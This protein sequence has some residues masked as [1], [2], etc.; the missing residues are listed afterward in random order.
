MRGTQDIGLVLARHRPVCTS[1][2]VEAKPSLRDGEYFVYCLSVGRAFAP[3][4]LAGEPAAS[5]F[6]APTFRD[7]GARIARTRAAS[8]RRPSP[9]LVQVVVDQQADLPTSP[10]RQAHCDALA[11][12]R[13]AVVVTGQQVGLFLGPLY[14]FYKAASA[15]AVARAL[16]AESGVPC[17]PVFWLQTEDHDFAEIRTAI[18][19]DPNGEPVRLDLP[20]DPSQ[21]A[22]TSVAYR[23]LPAQ[24]REL[25]STLGVA[26]DGG[27]GAD[28]VL[29]LLQDS[30]LPGAGLHR[31]FASLLATVFADEGLLVFNPRDAR[32]AAL[33]APFY[34]RCIE[35]TAPIETA[36]RER[37]VA[38]HTAGFDV[39]VPIRDHGAL[40]F[41]HR[42]TA[43]G[44]R[45]RLQQ[46]GENW[47]LAGAAERFSPEALRGLL[48]RDPLRFST[49]ALLR[50][51]VQDLLFPTAAYV[52]GPGEINYYAQMGPLYAFAGLT[53]PLLVPRG[54][55]VVVDART[56]RRLGQLGLSV[57]DV[58]VPGHA[59][60]AR[61]QDL[62]DGAVSVDDLRRRIATQVT[63]A[64][65]DLA[66]AARL[67][68]IGLERPA[69]RTLNSVAHALNRLLDRYAH[70]LLERDTIARR[71]LR[72]VE[73]ALFPNGTPQER[74]Y[75]WPHLAARLGPRTLKDLVMQ[76]LA[77]AGPF[78]SKVH[79]LSP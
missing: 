44:P 4:Y 34:R 39:Q 77:S 28:E 7:A 48:D 53:P 79:E 52:A 75:A 56:R 76:R 78:G 62:P 47:Q 30:Y 65:E 68:G 35:E 71:R 64:V 60:R 22:R 54:R 11:S 31:A 16:Q 24:V 43:S 46:K 32:I 42:E 33:A 23:T 57:R 61:V 50:P 15:I 63:P 74:F 73:L 18:V 49:S 59:L 8:A 70:R 2:S 40:V 51:V 12:G 26:L 66:A 58:G 45:F 25:L 13:A 55:F 67:P 17:V 29:S 37:E 9:E 19:S 1:L 20:D 38:L 27:P 72:A 6:F 21:D 5:P 36:L 3:S 14:S 41:F 10:A 69:E